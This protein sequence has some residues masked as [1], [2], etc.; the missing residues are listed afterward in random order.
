[1]RIL[2]SSSQAPFLRGGAELHADHLE[3][4]LLRA[5]HA[6]E[7][8][9]LPFKFSPEA[10]IERLMAF[11]EGFDM[12]A[13]NGQSVDQLI[14]LQFPGYGMAHPQHTAWVLHQHRAVYELFEPAQASPALKQLRARVMEFDGRV[15]PPLQ[16]RGRLFANSKRVAER[17]QQFNGV[18][19]RPLYH[20]PP[21]A[22]ALRSG[23]EW[24]YVFF[25]SRLETLKRQ[26]L[27]I[28]A[29]R[30]LRCPVKILIAGAGGQHARYAQLIERHGLQERVRL[31]GSF[32][33]AER[34]ALYQHALGVVFVPFDE[35]LGYIT[36]EA[37]FAAK[38]V[39]TCT[40]SGGPL[41]FV[42][43]GETGWV[44]EPEPEALAAA[45]EALWANKARS[46]AMGEAGRARM[47]ALGLSW[48]RVV[49]VL[50]CG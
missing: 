23:D 1:M 6:V 48:D 11:C 43:P 45:I 22:E 25:P 40:D 18:S 29:A 19:A 37:M 50:T 47:D 41:E 3:A 32:S 34:V 12:S 4:A 39:I 2:L 20:P 46:K 9:R 7:R 26:D 21:D 5:G 13:P 24:G 36:L 44:V 49:E 30:H 15:L 38:P 28:E 17:M 14:S 8:I 31:M 27:L 10:D 33:N 16:K 42:V 35:D